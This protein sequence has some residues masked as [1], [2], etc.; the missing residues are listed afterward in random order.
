ML[1]YV[2]LFLFGLAFDTLWVLCLHFTHT[3]DK[4]GR[5]HLAMLTSVMLAGLG[6]LSGAKIAH[7]EWLIL[8]ELLG[9]TMGMYV[10]MYVA[11][12]VDE[13]EQHHQA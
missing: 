11:D 13:R 8:P 2:L 10:G 6:A 1:A 9:M 4:R 5:R 7:D 3:R 12:K